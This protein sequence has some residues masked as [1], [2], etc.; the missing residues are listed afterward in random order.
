MSDVHVDELLVDHLRGELDSPERARVD[1]HLAECAQCRAAREGFARLMTALARTVRAEH[2]PHLV[3]AGGPEGTTTPELL[4]GRTAV[5][6]KP[7]AYV[8][9]SFTC[10]QPVTDASALASLL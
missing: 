2:R 1:A 4:Q 8:C 3:L 6:G 10:K 7:A 5:E 9:E